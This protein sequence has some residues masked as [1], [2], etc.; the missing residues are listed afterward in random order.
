MNLARVEGEC[1]ALEDRF[2]ANIGV[3]VSYLEHSH[4]LNPPRTG[5]VDRRRRDGGVPLLSVG[6][7]L[8]AGPLHHFVVPLPVPGRIS[9]AANI[10]AEIIDMEHCRPLPPLS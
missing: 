7:N 2:V 6:A 5:E 3:E 9:K 1:K 4:F 8:Q 10:G